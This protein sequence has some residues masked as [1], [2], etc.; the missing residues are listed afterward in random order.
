MSKKNYRM[1][2]PQDNLMC[3][4]YG[5]ALSEFT[6]ADI[7]SLREKYPEL[8]EK[9]DAE[10][11]A[12]LEA[13]IEEAVNSVTDED[14][15]KMWGCSIEESVNRSMLFVGWFE[16]VLKWDVENRQKKHYHIG[17][18]EPRYSSRQVCDMAQFF[19]RQGR[20]DQM[21][22]IE[23]YDRLWKVNREEKSHVDI[24]V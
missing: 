9:I 24:Q 14:F 23:E 21:N 18:F 15:Q 5:K 8:M 1:S 16:A 7:E 13:E 12:R 17:G 3:A 4:I 10:Q 19:Y 22:G 11:E 20:E 6:E 2:S